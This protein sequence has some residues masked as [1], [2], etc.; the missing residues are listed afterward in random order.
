[1]KSWYALPEAPL[2]PGIKGAEL[3]KNWT[4][5]TAVLSEHW[6]PGVFV[7]QSRFH[8]VLNSSVWTI[9]FEFSCYLLIVLL[10]ACTIMRRR[11][12]SSWCSVL[13]AACGDGACKRLLNL[14]DTNNMHHWLDAHGI[15]ASPGIGH[16]FEMHAWQ[17]DIGARGFVVSL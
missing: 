11:G 9:R 2:P 12:A 10:A 4:L 7:K 8:A 13:F 1:M 3:M 14:N 6:V 15:M 17:M 5:S 16:W